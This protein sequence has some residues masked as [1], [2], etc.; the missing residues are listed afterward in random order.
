MSFDG[1]TMSAVRRELAS[2]LG[3]AKIEKIIQPRANEIVLS[4]RTEKELFSLLCSADPQL[5]RIH[6]T[7]Q[8][9]AGPAVAPAFCMLLRKHLSGSR[10]L[11]IEQQGHER[12]L[13]FIFRSYDEAG[14]IVKKHLIVETMGKHSNIILAMPEK[15][16]K[17]KILG[18][19]KLVDEKMSRY[20]V[21]MPGQFYIP[22]PPQDKLDIFSVTEENLA[23]RLL[24][25]SE[26]PPETALML[27]VM[28]IGK[29]LAREIINAAA[30]SEPGHPLEIIRPL[31]IELN[32]LAARLKENRFIP[33]IVDADSCKPSLFFIHPP[34][35]PAS[36]LLR[37][38]SLNGALDIYYSSI[39]RGTAG[40]QLKQQLESIVRARFRRAQKKLDH[41]QRELQETE[42]ADKYRIWGELITASLFKISPGMD[43]VKVNNYYSEKMEEIEIPLNP[44][45][46]PQG[47]AG[48]YFKT[49]RKLHDGRKILTKRIAATK[50][51]IAYLESL[52][53]AC[54]NAGPAELE[55][56]RHELIKSR[57]ILP[58]KN[59]PAA[60]PAR[61]KPLHF[62]S[63][64]GIDIYVGRNNRQNDYLTLRA[65][66][67]N[68]IWLHVKEMPGSH[69]I[70]KHS[71]P[72]ESTLIY[73]AKLA[74]SYSRAANSSNVPVDYTRVRHVRK[75]KGAKP[76]M[77]I[78][79]HHKTIYVTNDKQKPQPKQK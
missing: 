45:L 30:G 1:I 71:D 72:P 56:I 21:V 5:A 79:D 78:Y 64:D 50:E 19:I 51:D 9:Q 60:K 18:S 41:Q 25:H 42:N 53:F 46:S 77:V 17:L 34:E 20:R 33:W 13:S 4:F 28:G 43:K 59:K 70:I 23:G 11:F 52:L 27:S 69:V 12:C 35:L 63:P 3:G 76:G 73:A 54:E 58:Q 8:K 44:A 37:C 38:D 39:V 36:R 29:N 47:N 74:A 68:D 66:D 32:K 26:K 14:D 49:Y 24:A 6:L 75:P 65:A 16:E 10:L 22:P 61:S 2:L 57:L 67:G 15:A 31:T 40:K 55:E 48:Y 62:L 7:K